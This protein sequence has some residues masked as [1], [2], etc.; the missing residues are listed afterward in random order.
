MG[1]GLVLWVLSQKDVQASGPLRRT[2][3]QVVDTAPLPP[4]QAAS[5]ESISNPLQSQ[6]QAGKDQM[7]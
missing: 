7:K 5:S 1:G 2:G 4:I 6:K 3:T